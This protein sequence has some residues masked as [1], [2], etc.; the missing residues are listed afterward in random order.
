MATA[1]DVL[2]V[3]R[4]EIGVTEYPPGSNNVKYN[5]EYY[6][7]QVYGDD[8][9]PWCMVFVWWVFKHAGASSLFFDGGKTASCPT[10]YRWASKTGRWYTSGYKPGDVVIFRF[11][12]SGYDHVGI[13]ETAN[14]DGTYTVIEGNTSLT[15][16]DNGG[17]VMRRT[18]YRSQ[19]VGAYRPEYTAKAS[20]WMKGCDV[21]E[22]QDPNEMDYSQ[23]DF[24]VI[25]A[26]EG[27]YTDAEVA[28]HLKKVKAAGKP[29]GFY[30]YAHPERNSVETEAQHFVSIVWPYVGKAIF[31]LDY[32]N[33]ALNVGPKWARQWL[34][35]VYE[36]TGV[37]PLIY[38]QGSAV[39]DYQ[40]VLD[41]DYGLWVTHWDVSSPAYKPWPFWAMWQY[42]NS[43]G[44]LDLDYFNGTEET[45]KKYAAQKK[46]EPEPEPEPVP[47]P[48]H[49]VLD[50][51]TI[52]FGNIDRYNG[53]KVF[54]K[55]CKANTQYTVKCAKGVGAGW[56]KDVPAYGVY[57][58]DYKA[59]G[60]GTPVFTTGADAKYIA[61]VVS[62]SVTWDQITIIEAEEDDE[63]MTQ[64]KFNEM[65]MTAMKEY[66]KSLQDNDSGQWSN[67]DKEW[68]TSNGLILG[69]GTLPDGQPN[70]M[71]QD[72]LTREQAAAVYHRFYDK[73]VK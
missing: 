40:E 27:L 18:R 21:S 44:K 17:A 53:Y 9:Y 14:N 68:A 55:N 48:D 3:A 46:V 10:Y 7:I 63:D 57:V 66:R 39:K 43:N 58:N 47:E 64:E 60:G 49:W 70:Y 6:G 42:T 24:V 13:V 12:S 37:R 38:L 41:G 51:A 4:G 19:I 34:D 26:S 73:F 29:F 69:S 67:A 33:K 1:N 22:W 36:L 61:M 71:W 35:R 56:T 50:N 65:F 25:R 2:A 5:T 30:H 11:S 8:A 32:E 62:S 16:D 45:W 28:F 72:F 15:S 31:A 54:Y 59:F 52:Y 20:N 23:Y